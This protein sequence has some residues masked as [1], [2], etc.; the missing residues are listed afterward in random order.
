MSSATTLQQLG[1]T[2]RLNAMTGAYNFLDHGNAVSFRFRG[3]RAANYVKIELDASDTYTVTFGK[4]SRYALT[5]VQD[6]STVYV[7]TLR[8]LFERVTGLDLTL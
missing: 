3:S 8:E 7:E 6:F 1:G 4:V 2:G 5:K